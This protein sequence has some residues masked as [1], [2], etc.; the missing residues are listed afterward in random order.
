MKAAIRPFTLAGDLNSGTSGLQ[1]SPVTG[2]ETGDMLT[3]G[4]WNRVLELVSQ[5]GGAGGGSGWESV[6]LTDTAAFDPSCDYRVKVRTPAWD[7]I[8]GVD[9]MVLAQ[10]VSPTIL[11][12]TQASGGVNGVYSNSKDKWRQNGVI[13]TIS[14]ILSI[15]KRC[16][17]TGGGGGSSWVN[18]PLTDTADYDTSCQYRLSMNF[19]VDDVNRKW[20]N[21]TSGT[22][23]ISSISPKYIGLDLWNNSDYYGVPSATKTKYGY[24][25][26]SGTFVESTNVAVTKIEKNCAGTGGGG[27]GG[28]SS[29]G[30]AVSCTVRSISMQCSNQAPAYSC[31]RA[32]TDCRAQAGFISAN[33]DGQNANRHIDCTV[34]Q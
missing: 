7:N 14:T 25:N 27:G 31:E 34:C 6:P 22:Y 3:A 24:R 20:H 26:T 21:A 2:K 5:G 9:P 10:Q 8:N 33:E 12:L 28:G 30:T 29:I 23:Y 4:E 15:D 17:G 18:V 1:S 19:I 11:V 32:R 13:S 16:G